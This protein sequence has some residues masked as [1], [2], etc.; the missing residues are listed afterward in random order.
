M[1]KELFEKCNMLK[2]KVDQFRPFEG[3][4]LRKVKDF[5]KIST[6][7]SSNALEGNTLTES[8]TKVLLEDG[9]TAAGKPLKHTLEAIGHGNAYE[10]MFMLLDTKEIKE[11]DIKKLH[12]LFYF[13][14]NS[15]Q[16]G[17]YR[18]EPV[19]ISGSNYSVSREMDIEKDMS[20]LCRW[21]SDNRTVL[22]PIEFA[23]KLHKEF[24]FIHPFID[25]NG[26]CA[27]LLMN[28]ALIQDGYLPCIIPPILRNE[29]ISY[30]EKAHIDDT[31]FID[32]IAALEYETEKDFLRLLKID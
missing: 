11:A 13:H 12:E 4:M 15:S 5:Y 21:I 27:R 30:L 14:I 2:L 29:Y 25:G 7:W 23:A 8:E 6:T 16:A 19:F 22:H 18:D 31:D 28:T 9:L 3:E 17:K 20:K 1:N 24:V 32:F 26:R 10:F